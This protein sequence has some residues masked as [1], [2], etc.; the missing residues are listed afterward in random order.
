MSLELSPDTPAIVQAAAA[1][2]L[3]LHIGGGAVALAG[4]GVASAA[5]KGG[6]LHRQAGSIFFAGMLVLG[7]T[8]SL[9]SVLQAKA[10]MGLGG[11]FVIYL[12]ATA[13]LTVAEPRKARGQGAKAMMVFGWGIVALSVAVAPLGPGSLVLGALAALCALADDRA[14]QA[15][16]LAGAARLR[17]HIWRSCAAF[18]VATGSFFLGQQKVMP[19][20]VQGNPLLFVLGLAPLG[21]MAFWLHRYRQGR[22]L[23]GAPAA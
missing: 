2:V 16:G 15:G 6:R 20:A 18:F 5:R 19:E 1:G 13:W 10:T 17:R 11:L 8:S 9:L 3:M 21:L 23:A 12:A 4:G 22:R 14:I 7:A